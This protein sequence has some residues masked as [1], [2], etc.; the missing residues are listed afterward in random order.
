MKRSL[1]LVFSV[2]LVTPSLAQEETLVSGHFHSGGYG[3]PVWRLGL[4]NGK[5]GLFSG[6][7]GGWIINHAVALGGGGYSLVLD[8]ETDEVSTDGKPLYLHL[9][10]GG[11]EVEYIHKSNK[12]IHWTIHTTIG[13]GTVK[14][15][16]HDPKEVT[17]SDRFFMVEPSFNMD[18]NVSHWF[19]IGVGGSYRLA[20]GV[21]LSGIT[22]SNVSGPSGLIILKFGIF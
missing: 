6:G 13:S 17:E 1:I 22:S 16:E 10:Y 9:N 8:V 14:L 5:V 11:F 18:V 12:V 2:L 20:M 19:R 7:R 4:V 21:D 15:R 3:G